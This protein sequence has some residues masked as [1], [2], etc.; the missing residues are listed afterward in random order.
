MATCNTSSARAT[1]ISLGAT[2]VLG[3]VFMPVGTQGTMKGVTSEQLRDC[4]CRIMLGNTYHLGLRPGMELMKS[5]GGLH[6]FANWSGALLTDSGGFQMVSLAKLSEVS[7]EGVLFQSPR[8]GSE[9]MLTPEKSMQLQMA[10]GADIIMQLDDVVPPLSPSERMEVA[11]ERSIRWLDRC[12]KELGDNPKQN[13]FSI[14]QGGLD[15]SLRQKCLDA[16]IQRSTPGYAIGGLSGGEDKDS[17]WRIVKY[18]VDRLPKDKPRYCMGIGYSIDLLI[19]VALGVD[20]FDCVF[21]T[22]TA[23]FGHA[24]VRKGSLSLKQA[25]YASDFRPIDEFCNCQTCRRRISRSF[26]HLSLPTETTACHLISIHNLHFQ[27]NFMKE[28]RESIIGGKFE[29][30]AKTFVK[31]KYADLG[32]PGWVTEALRS[33][34]IFL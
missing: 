24:L 2:D 14:I 9:M 27:L 1:V 19:C 21:V 34:N 3:P 20:M 8:D 6:R 33:V 25:Q 16:M 30:F 28:M 22:R 31:E 13:L 5:L 4:G 7:E 23:R 15:Y 26:L 11:T 12:I 18:C 17:F 10:I 29:D 32:I